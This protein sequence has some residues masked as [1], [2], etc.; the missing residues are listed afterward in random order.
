MTVAQWSRAFDPIKYKFT[1]RRDVAACFPALRR[2]KDIAVVSLHLRH[3][4][5]GGQRGDIKRRSEDHRVGRGILC[6]RYNVFLVFLPG[7][8]HGRWP[9]DSATHHRTNVTS[10]YPVMRELWADGHLYRAGSGTNE[11]EMPG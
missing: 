10:T 5:L 3:V 2:D 4:P 7:F 9:G 11:E 6:V 1:G 8:T